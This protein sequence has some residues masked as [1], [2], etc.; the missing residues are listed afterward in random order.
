MID[1]DANILSRLPQVVLD[2]ALS[3]GADPAYTFDAVGFSQRGSMRVSL[4]SRF[5]LPF[6][7][8]QTMSIKSCAFTWNARFLPLGYMTVTDELVDGGGRLDVTAL[9]IF[10]VARSK[11]GAA[12]ARGELIRYLAE[13]PLVPDAILH[14]R[15]LDWREIDASTIAVTSGSDDTACEVILGLGPD[16]RIV[17]AFCAN[18]AA[19]TTPP[20]VSMPWRGVFSDYRQVSGRW[21]PTAAQVGWVINGRE[22]S[23]WQ[24]RNQ[25]WEPL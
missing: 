4:K 22:E 20:F 14:N 11:P 7:A 10:P 2:L 21:I 23:Y 9:G 3:H 24:G 6:T 12:L 1:P 15:D 18:R 25:S 5:W 17:S 13:L 19:S 16:R 8:R